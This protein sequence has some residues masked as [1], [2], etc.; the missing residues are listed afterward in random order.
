MGGAVLLSII[1]AAVFLNALINSSKNLHNSML[2]EIL[3][4]TVLFFDTNPIGRILNRFSRDIGIV[5]ELLPDVFSG[6][7]TNRSVLRRSCCSS[8]YPEPLDYPASNPTHDDF[9]S[10]RALFSKNIT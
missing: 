10:D 6:G 8:V 4:A 1:R 2:S 7:C 3:K 9:Y 5:D